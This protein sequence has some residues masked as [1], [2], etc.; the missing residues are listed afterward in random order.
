MKAYLKEL[1]GKPDHHKQRF[2]LLV[3]GSVTAFIFVIWSVVKFGGA[4]DVVM[5][6]TGPVNLAAVEAS[7]IGVRP[8]DTI[9]RE[10]GETWRSLRNVINDGQ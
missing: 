4:E 5:R 7:E 1:R 2:A 10:L 8:L 6:E 9:L 3:S